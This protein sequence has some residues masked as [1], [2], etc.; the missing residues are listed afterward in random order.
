MVAN[1]KPGTMM[2]PFAGVLT[3]AEI[4]AVV[5]HLQEFDPGHRPAPPPPAK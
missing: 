5:R 4:D 3:D 1:G 2:A